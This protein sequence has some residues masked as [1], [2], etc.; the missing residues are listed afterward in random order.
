M[1]FLAPTIS[2]IAKKHKTYKNR[3]SFADDL[4]NGVDKYFFATV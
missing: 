2:C 1:H 4:S 3:R